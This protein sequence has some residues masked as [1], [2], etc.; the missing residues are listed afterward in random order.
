MNIQSISKGVYPSS[1]F[2]KKASSAKN[3]AKS[4]SVAS[5]T[6]KLPTNTDFKVQWSS[7]QPFNPPLSSSATLEQIIFTQTASGDEARIL[8]K[9]LVEK[10]LEHPLAKEYIQETIEP[11]KTAI[12][13]PGEYADY[14]RGLGYDEAEIQQSSAGFQL[15]TA[16]N[17]V[18]NGE[19]NIIFNAFNFV[20]SFNNK[21]GTIFNE[22][23]ETNL[24]QELELLFGK[25]MANILL[26]SSAVQEFTWAMHQKVYAGIF[27]QIAEENPDFLAMTQEQQFAQVKAYA[28]AMPRDELATLFNNG[29][30]ETRQLTGGN[31]TRNRRSVLLD[32]EYVT[33]AP[34]PNILIGLLEKEIFRTLGVNL[35]IR[36]TRD[37]SII[38]DATEQPSP[39]ASAF[40]VTA[41]L[42]EG[43]TA[44]SV[45]TGGNEELLSGTD[46]NDTITGGTGTKTIYG[47]KGDDTIKAGSITEA[48]YGGKGQD[49]LNG[50]NNTNNTLYGNNGS[51]LITGGEKDDLIFGGK[52]NDFIYGKGGNDTI[53]GDLGENAVFA[54][55]NPLTLKDTL[56]LTN[57]R[58]I[59]INP[60][61]ISVDSITS[62]PGKNGSTLVYTGNTLFATIL[63][64]QSKATRIVP[65]DNS[66]EYIIV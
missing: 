32:P 63:D 29:I 58:T 21:A 28:Q 3:T 10:A 39:F 64:G 19:R 16:V 51:D 41:D 5:P 65:F 7:S 17:Q 30:F 15:A 11:I 53:N 46:G 9:P 6:L 60:L 13:T 61:K 59:Y 47:N 34:D 50:N 37:P 44:G 23:L 45:I 8:A 42:N 40:E 49:K 38:S 2:S 62:R 33:N 52:G 12:M 20:D 66:G 57:I 1:L 24:R 18:I 25:E 43:Q 4:S 26:G 36:L 31:Y 14:L 22:L 56:T 27:N 48:V 55:Y 54:E 35:K